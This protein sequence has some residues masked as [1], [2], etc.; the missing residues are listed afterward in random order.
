[1]ALTLTPGRE[2][3]LEGAPDLRL[4]NEEELIDSLAADLLANDTDGVY[5]G[6]RNLARAVAAERYKEMVRQRQAQTAASNAAADQANTARNAQRAAARGVSP[7]SLPMDEYGSVSGRTVQEANRPQEE[8]E[9]ALMQ[10]QDLADEIIR[11]YREGDRNW[12]AEGDRQY[13]QEYGLGGF[14]Y[15]PGQT[16][17]DIRRRMQEQQGF[18]RTR[19]GMIPAGR[20]PTPEQVA[21]YRDFH[22]DW[23]NETP[24]SERQAQYNPEAYEEFR[25]GVRNDIRDRARNDMAT[26]GTGPDWKLQAEAD[27]AMRVAEAQEVGQFLGNLSG[28]AQNMLQGPLIGT[29]LA[30]L[31]PGN[32][33]QAGAQLAARQQ[34]AASEERVRIGQRGKFYRV[35]L[36]EESGLPLETARQMTD[37]QLEA[38]GYRMRSQARKADLDARRERVQMNARLAGGQPTAASRAAVQNMM[39]GR[40]R[41]DDLIARLGDQNM[42]DWQRAGLIAGLAPQANTVNPTPLSVD[43]MGAQNAFRMMQGMGLGEGLMNNPAMQQQVQ[44]AQL[45]QQAGVLQ[46]AEDHVMENYA[47]DATDSFGSPF[48][49]AEQQATV[50]Y[51]MNKYGPPAGRMTLAQAQAIV[52]NIATRKRK[53][54]AAPPAAGP[55]AGGGAGLPP[56]G[57][58]MPL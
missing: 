25:E 42:T 54:P 37:A 50:D 12:Q 3:R 9:A 49:L 13:S 32:T 52:D 35:K 8:A 56:P 10:D 6:D 28:P 48:D 7:E 26:Y 46:D 41:F 24:G 40:D 16:D 45:Q 47:W 19:Q 23:A 33:S 51:L 36:E 55:P 14:E 18:I 1:M 39:Q 31:T 57:G 4:P 15:G 30:R 21:N 43:A 5:G 20:S 53:P 29:D 2:M 38:E 11:G 58:R 34:R 44:Q 22:Y 27:E 17:L